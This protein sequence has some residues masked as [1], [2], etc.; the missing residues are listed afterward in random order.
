MTVVPQEQER[1]F[2]LIDGVTPGAF[3]LIQM[4]QMPVPQVR[5]GSSPQ[6]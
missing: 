3:K 5:D 2:L 4:S 1:E 6:P